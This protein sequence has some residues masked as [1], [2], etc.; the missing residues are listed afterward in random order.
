[1]NREEKEEKGVKKTE[2]VNATEEKEEDN[3]N[4]KEA[5]WISKI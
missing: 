3:S 1:M 5:E 4:K 2:G